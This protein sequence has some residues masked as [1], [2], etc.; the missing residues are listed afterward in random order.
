MRF[1]VL[2][3][4]FVALAPAQ[5]VSVGLKAGVPFTEA[6]HYGFSSSLLDTGRWTVGPTIEFRLVYGFSVEA[7]ALYRGYRLQESFASPT[8]IGGDITYPPLFTS[9]RS[10]TKVW[11][12]PVL[13]KYRFGSRSFRPFLDA[14]Y[15]WS[16]STSDVTSSLVCLGTA[17]TCA[18]S[19]LANY[20]QF[21]GH[22]N[23]T[24]NLGGPTGGVG[25][26][27]K[28]GKFKLAPEVRYTHYSNPTSNVASVLVGF[29][30]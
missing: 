16:H 13:L 10:D 7:D 11:D 2:F 28:V 25:V 4:L 3:F 26:E 27:F 5:I 23:T 9:Y 1:F 22:A 21:F 20:Y 17:D 18:G 12:F 8:F 15:A 24:N 19:N 29:T 30:F 14:G 6:L